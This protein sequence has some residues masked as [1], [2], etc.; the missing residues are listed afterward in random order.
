[1]RV[2][3]FFILAT[4]LPILSGCGNGARKEFNRLLVELADKDQLVD[5]SDWK[6]ISAFIDR[7]KAHFKDFYDHGRLDVDDVEDYIRDFFSHRRPP[8]D[9]RFSDIDGKAVTFH[10]FLEQSASMQAY[11]SPKGDGSFRAAIMSLQNSLPGQTKVEHIGEK[12]Y[13]D[14]R[15]IFDNI[16]NRTGKNE[17]SILV[18]DL[19]YSV[20][21]M[22]G[23]NP[24]KVFNELQEMV[25]AVFKDEVRRKS[26]LVVRMTGSYNGPYYSF[27]NQPHPY[28]GRR[29]YYIVVVADNDVMK[30]LTTD[31]RFRSFADMPKLRGYDNMVLF[32]SDD[33]YEPYYSLLLNNKALRGHF[34]PERGQSDRITRLN[35]IEPDKDSGDIQLALAVDLSKMFIDPR[36]LTDKNNYVVLSDDDVRIK[37]IRPI[38]KSDITPAEK[39]YIGSATHIFILSA[40]RISNDQEVEIEL[41]NQ[42]PQWVNACSSEN[43]VK[44][45][46]TTTFG[47]RYLLGGIYDSYMRNAEHDANYFELEL[48]LDK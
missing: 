44:P 33:I 22:Q 41:R 3:I 37:E 15:S 4:I 39:K 24:Q 38:D 34:H 21:D 25:N 28:D 13:T 32:T 46:A 23:V 6:Q 8:K 18:S 5:G 29:P 10:I 11:D 1:M 42:L 2:L 48:H 16:L 7:N 36:Y 43:D 47:L 30:Q 40:N 17:V 14:F 31:S 20:K 9:I 26:M 27:D 19:I 12:G 35:D 45:D